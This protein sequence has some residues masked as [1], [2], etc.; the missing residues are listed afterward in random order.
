MTIAVL[1]NFYLLKTKKEMA[2]RGA[3]FLLP[4]KVCSLTMI[5][6]KE[7]ITTTLGKSIFSSSLRS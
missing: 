1:L 3:F 4:E 7:E 2:A 5:K 6:L